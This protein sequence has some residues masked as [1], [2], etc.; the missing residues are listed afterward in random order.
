M[1]AHSPKHARRRGAPC[2]VESL[3]P[4][5]HLADTTGPV[6]AIDVGDART[7]GATSHAVA[8]VYSDP[9][10]VKLTTID[11]GDVTVTRDS[12]GLVMPVGHTT[13][14][15]PGNDNSSVTVTYGLLPPNLKS[16]DPSADGRY[17]VRVAAGAVT[18]GLDNPGVA[19]SKSFDV[20]VEALHD[21]AAPTADLSAADVT[22]AGGETHAVQVVF[23]DDVAVDRESID[24]SDLV[25]TGP[26]GVATQLTSVSL[27]EFADAPQVV[28]TFH[29]RAPGGVFDAA[30]AGTYTASLAAGSVTDVYGK[31]AGAASGSFSVAIPP[32]EAPPVATLHRPSSPEFGLQTVI[33][34]YTDDGVI[35]A[36]SIDKTDLS[37]AGPGGPLAVL[38]ATA[39]RMGPGRFDVYYGVAPPGGDGWSHADNGTYAVSVTPGAVTD[40]LGRGVAAAAAEFPVAIPEPFVGPDLKVSLLPVPFTP[41]YVLPGAAGGVL[42][43]VTNAGERALDDRVVVKLVAERGGAFGGDVVLAATPARR[44]RLAPGASR[45]IPMRFTHLGEVGTDYNVVAVVDPDDA[46]REESEENNDSGDGRHVRVRAAFTDI[47]AGTLPKP[48]GRPV[49]PIGGRMALTVKVVNNGNATFRGVVNVDAF[50][51][52]GEIRGP[53][54]V[55]LGRGTVAKPVVVRAASATFVRVVLAIDPALP[56]GDYV[57]KVNVNAAP[58]AAEGPQD[59]YNAA[60]SP[61]S[62]RYRAG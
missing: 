27:S 61:L 60:D 56:P 59:F 11:P 34:V 36:A 6:A 26:P 53:G 44:M 46:V 50:G 39:H 37:V 48:R 25:V 20:A 10:L 52:L 19:A 8:V 15:Y 16:F 62:L 29:L 30:D 47:T 54:Y 38:S 31:L 23:N 42:V 41:S 45:V 14:S 18:D 9:S 35:D 17:T 32:D 22:A 12:D 33:V 13:F 40:S 51:T 49:I 24:L 5:T 58:R 28:A 43:K 57:L 55:R 7:W 21:T 4:R 2:R 3:E 1:G